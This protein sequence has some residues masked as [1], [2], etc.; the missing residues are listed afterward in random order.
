ML[1]S[2]IE[3][4]ESVEQLNE[5]F[6]QSLWLHK[7]IERTVLSMSRSLWNPT[8]YYS[9]VLTNIFGSERFYEIYGN[10]YHIP[11]YPLVSVR[12]VSSIGAST[13]FINKNADTKIDGIEI[14]LVVP[15]QR[16]HNNQVIME[17]D[18]VIGHEIN[19]IIQKIAQYK[20]N[21]I[22]SKFDQLTFA[23]GGHYAKYSPI[24]RNL[25]GYYHLS[26]KE[27]DSHA[28]TYGIRMWHQYADDSVKVLR[29]LYN[30]LWSNDFNSAKK[31]R[32]Q[33]QTIDN[34]VVLGLYNFAN[35]FKTA[36]QY[37]LLQNK[38]TA[39]KLWNKLFREIYKYI[40][41]R[42]NISNK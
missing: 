42:S 4:Y 1:I 10:F 13:K 22:P 37:K 14:T 18:S 6:D 35:A 32:Y 2:D 27:F 34:Q 7:I 33:N 40:C 30:V 31:I 12:E 23:N 20:Q 25:V 24:H 21:Y 29:F 9:T 19:H 28:Y 39:Q 11:I 41:S 8:Q 36:E 5:R 15:R 3:I 16:M 17:L 26:I 38:L